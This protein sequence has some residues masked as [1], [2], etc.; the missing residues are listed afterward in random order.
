[1]DGRD[2]C[3][4]DTDM[5]EHSK[6]LPPIKI[7]EEDERESR[8][9]HEAWNLIIQ[10]AANI[11]KISCDAQRKNTSL[12]E[13]ELVHQ[14]SKVIAQVCKEQLLPIIPPLVA[15]TPDALPELI[16]SVDLHHTDK[17][18]RCKIPELVNPKFMQ[19]HGANMP[20]CKID[21]SV[22]GKKRK[23]SVESAK[24]QGTSK[25]A[26]CDD[27]NMNSPKLTTAS[28][29]TVCIPTKKHRTFRSKQNILNLLK[30]ASPN[31]F[32]V[33]SFGGDGDGNRNGNGTRSSNS[34]SGGNLFASTE[35]RNG[36]SSGKKHKLTLSP[37]TVTSMHE[38]LPTLPQTL[39]PQLSHKQQQQQQSLLR[40]KTQKNISMELQPPLLFSVVSPT[41]MPAPPPTSFL[42]SPSTLLTP[43]PSSSS[44]FEQ[45]KPSNIND[46]DTRSDVNKK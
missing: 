39:H 3:D 44:S 25:G 15:S 13:A 40:H 43:S 2:D 16:V 36:I 6:T 35:M 33:G 31:V 38:P 1:M 18:V 12:N 19:E 37:K 8:S 23:G 10:T 34:G 7:A 4:D 9:R 22:R 41:Q 26:A 14:L 29:S 11:E 45:T 24:L 17:A 46:S 27:G 32:V 20:E 42:P 28:D 30:Y 5:E 21:Q